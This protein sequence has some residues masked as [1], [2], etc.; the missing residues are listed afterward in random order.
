MFRYLHRQFSSTAQ[1]QSKLGKKALK[2]PLEVQ[3]TVSPF[4]PNASFPHCDR[5]VSVSGEKGSLS[6]PIHPYIQLN[7]LQE[8]N[9]KKVLEINVDNPLKISQKMM[10][11][12]TRA[13]IARML[14]GVTEGFTLPIRIVGV[15]YRASLEGDKLALKVGLSYTAMVD[16]PEGVIVTVPNPQRVVVQGIDWAKMTQFAANVRKTRKPEPYNQK[17]IF[18]GDETI[19]KKEGK[20]R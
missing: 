7:H 9:N 20:K 3:F 18:V 16:I 4:T 6:L 11:G 19:K 14:E 8:E 1:C 13:L 12:T 15:G 5:Q 10:W 2:Y 17:G